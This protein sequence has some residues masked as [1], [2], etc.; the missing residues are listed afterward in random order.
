MKEGFEKDRL[1][2]ELKKAKEARKSLYYPKIN[3]R[4][5]GGLFIT[6]S[7]INSMLETNSNFITENW[8]AKADVLYKFAGMERQPDGDWGK[9][10]ALGI[11]MNNGKQSYRNL[12]KYLDQSGPGNK[13][14]TI[15]PARGFFEIESGFMLREEFRL[16][17]GIGFMHYNLVNDRQTANGNK[18]YFIMTAGISPRLKSFLEM[19]FN[20][21][22]L[23]IDNKLYPR[24]NVNLIILLKCKR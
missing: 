16:S 18:P 8:L 14:D 5:G 7:S 22:W 19:D 24:A 6:D 2:R 21:S 12:S 10:H 23:L 4:I 15:K 1:A 9:G 11:F 13:L 3:I 17:G 20:L